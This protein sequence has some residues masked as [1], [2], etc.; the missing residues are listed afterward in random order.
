MAVQ[1]GL[2]ADLAGI[3]TGDVILEVAG[4][5]VGSADELIHR[6]SRHP[7]GEEVD[8]LLA[9]YGEGTRATS[10]RLADRTHTRGDV[11][12]ERA[13]PSLLDELSPEALRLGFDV[14]E[15]AGEGLRIEVVDPLSRAWEQG[16]RPGTTILRFGQEPISTVEE[17]SRSL[18]DLA[19]GE[20]I[21]ILARGGE[22]GSSPRY[23][24]LKAN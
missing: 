5:P 1:P 8:V 21:R 9:R 13:A 20:V 15:T 22:W 17:F 2:P 7:P 4:R 6:I 11:E 12:E 18:E 23:L 10:V 19:S 16:L 14:T 24:Y 3:E